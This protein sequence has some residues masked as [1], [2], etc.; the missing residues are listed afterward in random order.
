MF[1]NLRLKLTLVN[2]SIIA[3]LFLLL[4]VGAYFLVQDRM[5]KNTELFMDRMA[6]DLING[7]HIM[8]PPPVN[9][10]PEGPLPGGPPPPGGLPLAGH[11]SNG[12]MPLFFFVRLDT[13]EDIVS[14][15]PFLSLSNSYLT[16]LVEETLD[17]DNVRGSFEF[18][19][20]EYSYLKA[21][22]PKNQGMFIIYKDATHDKTALRLMITALSFTGLICVILSFFGSL[23]VANKAMYP[24]Q[25]AWQQQ[26]DFLADA[27]HELRT[28]LSII[29]MNL[30]AV[31]ANPEETVQEQTKWL[32]NIAEVTFGMSKLVDS[33]LFLARI[34]SRQQLLQKEYFALHQAVVLTA[35]PFLPM[36][37]VKNI[38]LSIRAAEEIYYFGDEAKI[39]QVIG[40]LL[41]NAI[42]HT[43]ESGSITT[44]LK[45]QNQTAVLSVTDTGEGI[46]SEHLDKIF[47]RFYQ[48]DSARA[49]GGTGL[50]LSIAKWIVETHGGTIAVASI[51]GK[52]TTFTVRLPLKYK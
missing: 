22:L 26:K 5:E 37:Q 3:L 39:R 29:Q 19:E 42:R 14:F 43:P 51:P 38:S 17:I 13:N 18:R 45:C 24:I 27:S 33:L 9:G 31:R 6:D 32:D 44:S 23:I 50:G 11:P 25:Q 21:P 40:I 47:N 8:L 30:E 20:T 52:E 48:V 1:R 7:A 34:D 15:S 16:A 2:M 10:P 46:A 4:T 49:K 35:N 12:P 28:P 36:A 41:D